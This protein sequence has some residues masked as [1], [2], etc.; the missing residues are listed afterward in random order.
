MDSSPD[1]ARDDVERRI[2]ATSDEA[3]LAL[4]ANQAY[5]AG[6]TEL[7]LLAAERVPAMR[8]AL[9]ERDRAAAKPADAVGELHDRDPDPDAIYE[10][11]YVRDEDGQERLAD[12]RVH[13]DVRTEKLARALVARPHDVSTCRARRRG[14][15]RQLRPARRPRR[16]ASARSPGRLASDDDDPSAEP[17]TPLQRSFG[18]FL[19]GL[20]VAAD[21]GGEHYRVHLDLCAS[22]LAHEIARLSFGQ[23]ERAA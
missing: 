16:R 18:C 1:V 9:D 2:L 7:Y 6:W 12:V 21:A 5:A 17:L 11:G 10:P 15:S 3:K 23:H 8:E 13:H 22:R 20:A 14:S 4:L 19:D